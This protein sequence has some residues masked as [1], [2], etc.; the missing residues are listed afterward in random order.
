MNRKIEVG[1]VCELI[2]GSPKMVV[3]WIEY[4]GNVHLVYTA[5]GIV[6]EIVLPEHV[7]RVVSDQNEVPPETE[8]DD[9]KDFLKRWSS[10][11][12]NATNESKLDSQLTA[13]FDPESFISGDPHCYVHG[14]DYLIRYPRNF[15]GHVDVFRFDHNQG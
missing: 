2:T 4:N 10:G 8:T 9:V 12:V 6:T 3:S 15:R 13:V 5:N 14:P 1:S 11:F 7:L